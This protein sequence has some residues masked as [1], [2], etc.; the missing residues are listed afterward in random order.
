MPGIG[1]IPGMG[2]I[3]AMPN[4]GGG[5]P[6]EGLSAWLTSLGRGEMYLLGMGM[7]V[8]GGHQDSD[9]A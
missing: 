5:T 8:V 6:A 1:G 7:V 2:G 4:G 9:P 3:P